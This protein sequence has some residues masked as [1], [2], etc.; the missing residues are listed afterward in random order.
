MGLPRYKLPRVPIIVDG[1]EKENLGS[2]Y[3]PNG[4]LICKTMELAWRN[5]KVGQTADTASCIPLGIH[6]FEKMPGNDHYPDGYFRARQIAGRTINHNYKDKNGQSMSSV[7]MHPITY[8]KDLLGCIG[9]GSRLIDLNGDGVPDMA[10]SKIKL[11]W[12]VQNMP[13]VFELEIYIKP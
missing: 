1:V 12:M 13:D 9:V 11:K 5:N 2:I 4:D 6:I 10:E 3:A 8:V 7:L